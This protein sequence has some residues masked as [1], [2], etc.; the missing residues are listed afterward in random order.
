MLAM[1]PTAHGC[2][3]PGIV[4]TSILVYVMNVKDVIE[5]K[6]CTTVRAR[7]RSRTV[8][9]KEDLAVDLTTTWQP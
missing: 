9:R 4:I 7:V 1:A 3:I 2:Q 8:V 6:F 5:K